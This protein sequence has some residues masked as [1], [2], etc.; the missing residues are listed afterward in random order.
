[1]SRHRV[2]AR[3][4][5]ATSQEPALRV[6]QGTD[7]SAYLEDAAHYPG[8]HTPLVVCP[9]DEYQLATILRDA[10]TVLAVGAQ[11]SLTGGATPMGDTV[12]SLSKLAALG[13]PSVDAVTA[14]PGVTLAGLREALAAAGR[15]YP[16][17]PTYEGATVGGVVSTNAAGA[18][19]FKYG[20]TRQWVRGLSIMLATG[21]LLD[22]ERGQVR[23]ADNCFEIVTSAGT[24]QVPVP[25][26]RLPDVPKRAA[27]YPA[28]PDLDLIDMFIGS[29]GTLGIVTSVTLEVLPRCPEVGCVLIACRD[30]GQ[31]VALASRLRA[32]SIRTWRD[33][34]P[35]G[36]D[37]IAI[38]YM[39]R[40]CLE[41]LR[42]D[43]ATKR[44]G[45]T[46]PA[47]ANVLLLAQVEF[48]PG[49]TTE[50]VYDDVA[51]VA[52]VGSASGRMLDSPVTRL[53]RVVA[54]SDR[55]HATEIV[56]PG[57][58]ARVAALMALREAVPDGVN[59]RVG[60]AKRTVD[61]T[62]EKTAAD[63]I[64]PYAQ[65]S[66]SLRLFRHAFESRGLD[67]AIWGHLSD[68]NMHPNVIPRSA[69][70]VQRGKDAILECGRGV[71]QLGGCPLAEHG[72]GRNPVKQALL[73]QLYGDGG[74]AEMYAVKQALD[75]SRKL[76][77]GVLLP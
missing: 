5:R 54:E 41:L 73:R 25:T 32:E 58:A 14:E 76:A 68:A 45:V 24:I 37:V 59:R 72:V 35:D 9:R 75:P 70:D 43:G 50:Q 17:V 52:D 20:T 40:R 48:P 46:M 1:M 55:L 47:D 60:I 57:D 6:T 62:I 74:I 8:G 69:D 36:L 15:A 64:V 33:Q 71:I 7:V 3:P 29:E 30:E 12:I 67:Y 4:P 21:E 61:D 16:P 22:L 34:D 53:C 28:G 42:D 19:T 13:P 44:F 18:A 65:L 56:A 38:E 11:S 26:Y 23:A 31:A 2:R 63:M 51:G 39:D 77:P 66:E 10:T 49:T 27:G